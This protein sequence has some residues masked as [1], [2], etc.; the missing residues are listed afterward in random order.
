MINKFFITKENL[1]Q[2]S[3]KEHKQFRFK[4]TLL[5]ELY[6]EGAKS[7]KE[8]S[9]VMGTSTPTTASF[10]N[11]LLE[12][13]YV[14]EYGQGLSNGGRRPVLYA[15]RDDSFYVL[16]IDIG[17]YMTRMAVF[18]ADNQFVTSKKNFDITLRND[19]KF[20]EDIH[21]AGESLLTEYNIPREKLIAVGIAMP[22]LIDPENGINY[23]WFKDVQLKEVFSEKFG[24]TVFIENDANVRAIGENYFGDAMGYNN[25][26]ILHIDW[27]IGL[28]MILDGQLYHGSSGFAGEF[29]HISIDKDGDF[30]ECG[31]RGCI[32]RYASAKALARNV[33]AGIEAGKMTHLQDM[34]DEDLSQLSVDLIV[35]A[36]RDGDLYAIE[37]ISKL[38]VELGR[39]VAMLISL[40]DPEIILLSGRVAKAGNFLLGP[41]N[42]EARKLILKE[43]I[44]N[45]EIMIS[46][47]P[48]EAVT[49]GG[50]ALVMDKLF[51]IA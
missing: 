23:T 13:G 35:K 32:Q 40:Y 38:A 3:P 18:N 50:M 8:L 45:T 28:G 25:A 27:G 33:K 15:L 22:G 31:K 12:E 29:G 46:E 11:Q 34:V 37:S 41:L 47:N 26:L 24:T 48:D 2:L 30:C 10:I 49:L 17:V 14:R 1:Q 4:H 20:I 43:F 42:D 21:E 7:N 6:Y 39:G 9:R 5:R 16:S 19:T 44:N 36:A 51:H